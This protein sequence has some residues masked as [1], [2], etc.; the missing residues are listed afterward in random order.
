MEEKKAGEQVFNTEPTEQMSVAMVSM[1]YDQV[2]TLNVNIK[3]IGVSHCPKREL[4]IQIIILSHT[5]YSLSLFL[6]EL[7]SF[8]S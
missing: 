5:Q 2:K 4:R 6:V 1:S 3:I 8:L 7:S